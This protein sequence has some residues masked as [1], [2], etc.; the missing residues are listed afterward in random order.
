MALRTSVDLLRSTVA[1]DLVQRVHEWR[2]GKPSDELFPIVDLMNV[3]GPLVPVDIIHSLRAVP[4][5]DEPER[6]R[7]ARLF[8]VDCAERSLIRA[9]H[10]GHTPDS[11]SWVAVNVARQYAEGCRSA[12]DLA[13]ARSDALLASHSE[14]LAGLTAWAASWR[15]A[16]SSPCK[17]ASGAAI[18]AAWYYLDDVPMSAIASELTYQT[19]ALRALLAGES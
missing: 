4:P 11:R 7:V 17:A 6:D 8:A 15:T 13:I 16:S 1:Y 2:V 9:V 18:A 14:D 12:S 19:R 5:E 10:L 3:P